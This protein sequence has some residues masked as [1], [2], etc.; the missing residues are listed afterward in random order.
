MEIT[1][2][3]D[4]WLGAVLERD[5]THS[6]CLNVAQSSFH[7]LHD[8]AALQIGDRPKTVKTVLPALQ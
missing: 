3:I 1:D 2:S 8:Q 6:G 5:K 4:P 7:A